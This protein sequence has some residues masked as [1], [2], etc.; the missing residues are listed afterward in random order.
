M[1]FVVTADPL[2][3]LVDRTSGAHRDIDLQSA[4]ALQPAATTANPSG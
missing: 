1:E 2:A 4:A 3:I